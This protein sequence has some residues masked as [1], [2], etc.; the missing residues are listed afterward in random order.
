MKKTAV[1]EV[2]I[3]EKV[4]FLIYFLSCLYFLATIGTYSMVIHPKT[5]NYNGIRSLKVDQIYLYKQYT[6]NTIKLNINNFF[7]V[8]IVK[9]IYKYFYFISDQIKVYLILTGTLTLL[10]CNNNRSE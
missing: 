4:I 2:Y 1:S 9:N 6:I 10:S 8:K 7:S 3:L 5:L